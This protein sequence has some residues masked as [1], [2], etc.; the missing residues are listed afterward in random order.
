[1]RAVVE[2]EGHGLWRLP[3][4]GSFL[5]RFRGNFPELLHP[6]LEAVSHRE[7]ALE[8]RLAAIVHLLLTR[9][10]VCDNP[11]HVLCVQTLSDRFFP[12]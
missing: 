10:P 1:M 6:G 4:P 5:G 9:P 2:V 12:T 3:F 8:L 11:A 7:R